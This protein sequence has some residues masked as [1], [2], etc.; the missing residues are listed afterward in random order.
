MELDQTDRSNEEV[1]RR[2]GDA[3]SGYGLERGSR[4]VS[5][6]GIPPPS[7]IENVPTDQDIEWTIHSF[8]AAVDNTL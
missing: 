6:A 7:G 2:A 5:A 4:V 3:I 1:T 8:L